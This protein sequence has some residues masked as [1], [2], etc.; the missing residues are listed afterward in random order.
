MSL[1][2]KHVLKL[3][4][5]RALIP[6]G[7]IVVHLI[8]FENDV[9]PSKEAMNFLGFRCLKLFCADNQLEAVRRNPCRI[10]PPSEV[11]RQL[12]RFQVIIRI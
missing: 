9:L 10:Y 12:P 3:A 7:I 11:F 6:Y 5:F 8:N 2:K 1:N 4:P